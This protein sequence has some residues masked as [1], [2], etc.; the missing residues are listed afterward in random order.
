MATVF[1]T[2]KTMRAAD[3]LL[4]H[5][6]MI[7]VRYTGL[8]QWRNAII[9][10]RGENPGTVR[11]GIWCSEGEIVIAGKRVKKGRRP[12]KFTECLLL[13]ESEAR[14]LAVAR[15]QDPRPEIQRA[16][17]FTRSA[18]QRKRNGQFAD[19]THQADPRSTR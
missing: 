2:E 7:E 12:I 9:L 14:L 5:G 1:L 3:A 6:E 19:G 4:Q 15:E 17:A 11:L 16:L 8:G 10:G 18:R 13:P